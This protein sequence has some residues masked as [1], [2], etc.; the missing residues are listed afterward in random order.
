VVA[1]GRRFNFSVAVVIGNRKGAV[2][3]G[4]GKAGDTAAAIEKAERDAR[5]RLI[6]VSLTDGASIAHDVAAKYCA[7]SIAISP[8]PGRGLVAGS[9]VRSVLELA[10][11]SDV[12]AKILS[13]S[14]NRL[15]N[16]RATVKALQTL[17]Q[18]TPIAS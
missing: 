4:L 13:R 7:A 14:K 9:S 12:T 10:G 2:G 16:A 15:N 11:V 5:K 1:G 18:R 17:R 6:R 3:V 8:S